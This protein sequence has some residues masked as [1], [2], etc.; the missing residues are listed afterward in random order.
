[1]RAAASSWLRL[2]W[3][4]RHW[5][6]VSKLGL[7][8]NPGGTTSNRH[9]RILPCIFFPAC[10]AA[11]VMSPFTQ[12]ASHTTEES[13]AEQDQCLF[14]HTHSIFPAT[15][16]ECGSGCVISVRVLRIVSDLCLVLRFSLCRSF[17]SPCLLV[18]HYACCQKD[19]QHGFG[20]CH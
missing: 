16:R 9:R 5:L 14:V 4:G 2:C 15:H 20:C 17:G 3:P 19:R 6:A 18:R 8:T 11:L 1:M 12:V 10:T 7:V 13:S